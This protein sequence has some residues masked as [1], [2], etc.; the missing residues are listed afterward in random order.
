MIIIMNIVSHPHYCLRSQYR[1]EQF[2]SSH[3]YYTYLCTRAMVYIIRVHIFLII[4]AYLM[5]LSNFLIIH[6]LNSASFWISINLWFYSYIFVVVQFFLFLR[7][8]VV[9]IRLQC[10]FRTVQIRELDHNARS[11][12]MCYVFTKCKVLGDLELLTLQMSRS[13]FHKVVC[14]RVPSILVQQQSH[15]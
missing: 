11:I 9:E 10:T 1:Q 13:M 14:Q 15:C 3:S 12:Q 4:S 2:H 6:I 5:L 7:Y 8:L